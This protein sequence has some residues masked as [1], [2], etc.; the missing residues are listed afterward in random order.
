MRWPH[1]AILAAAMLT[2]GVIG[3]CA[4]VFAGAKKTSE[5]ANQTAEDAFNYVLSAHNTT[6]LQYSM[7]LAD[8]LDEP[9]DEAVREVQDIV[10]NHIALKVQFASESPEQHS[11]TSSEELESAKEAVERLRNR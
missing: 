10:A 8:K 7:L 4:G 6:E 1:F 2:A 11:M 3:F 9:P 5:K